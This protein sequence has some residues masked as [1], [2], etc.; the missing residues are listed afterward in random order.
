MEE[1][2][3]KY[4]KAEL[5]A[6]FRPGGLGPDAL[7]IGELLVALDVTRAVV[8]AV[9]I[10]QTRPPEIGWAEWRRYC[11]ASARYKEWSKRW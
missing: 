9:A 1:I 10:F 6:R 4:R 2:R 11:T 3:E 5:A 8:E 7:L